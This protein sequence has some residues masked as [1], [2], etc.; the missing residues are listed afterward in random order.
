MG[1]NFSDTQMERFYSVISILA[2]RK[3]VFNE[4]WISMLISLVINRIRVLR[5]KSIKSIKKKKRTVNLY[6]YCT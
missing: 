3:F 1:A 4:E 5:I 6:N 2:K